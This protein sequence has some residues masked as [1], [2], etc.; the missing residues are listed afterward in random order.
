MELI[1]HALRLLEQLVD[2]GN[3]DVL[4]RCRLLAGGQRSLLRE[5]PESDE[6]SFLVVRPATEHETLPS[7]YE[8]IMVKSFPFGAYHLLPHS[9][10][11]E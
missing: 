5:L 9:L 3:C 10:A 1:T 2:I 4:A 11:V 7:E 8:S 6:Q